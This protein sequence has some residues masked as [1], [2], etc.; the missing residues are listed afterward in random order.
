MVGLKA[1]VT[2][3]WETQWEGQVCSL[4]CGGKCPTWWEKQ[5]GVGPVVGYVQHGGKSG[6]V[7]DLWLE[8]PNMVGKAGQ[9]WTCGRICPIWWENLDGVGPVVGNV[10]N[11]RISV[12]VL[13]LR[14]EM[15]NMVEKL[16]QC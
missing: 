5:G 4:L 8:M 12:T 13:D 16:E 9:C 1:P 14:W 15:S 3:L 2:S 10:Q 7:L 11:G 6:T